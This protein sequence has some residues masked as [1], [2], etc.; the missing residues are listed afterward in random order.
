MLLSVVATGCAGLPVQTAGVTKGPILVLPPRD[1]VQ[2][3]KPHEAGVGSGERLGNAVVNGLRS[4]GWDVVSTDSG[5]FNHQSEAADSA[6][7][8]EGKR[9]DAKYVLQLV[10]GE[11]RD[12]AA[13]TFRADYVTLDKA[14]LLECETGTAAWFLVRPFML[15]KGNFGGYLGLVGK[16]G[17]LVAASIVSSAR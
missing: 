15:E 3:S 11:F 2:D 16:F 12:A 17:S 7:I 6:A 8:A 14:V 1:V 10:L 4:Q 13:M 9:L 5:E